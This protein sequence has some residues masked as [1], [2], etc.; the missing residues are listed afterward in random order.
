MP[1][2]FTSYLSVGDT[3]LG[4]ALLEVAVKIITFLGNLMYTL[5]NF[6]IDVVIDPRVATFLVA[7]L[8]LGILWKRRQSKKIM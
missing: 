5:V 7:A 3:G 4:D 6:A 8:I 2:T 1:Q